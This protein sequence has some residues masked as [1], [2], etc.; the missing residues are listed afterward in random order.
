MNRAVGVGARR[1]ETSDEIDEWTG[2]GDQCSEDK[3]RDRAYVFVASGIQRERNEHGWT[4][5]C[6]DGDGKTSGNAEWANE[7]GFAH[8]QN[9]EGDELEHKRCTVE[10]EVDGNEALKGE[11]ESE[12]PGDTADDDAGPG[13]LARVVRVRNRGSRPSFANA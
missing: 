2:R 3:C 9:D 1:G 11:P 12:S 10:D 4:D 7:G 6:G 8:A 5:A 13:N